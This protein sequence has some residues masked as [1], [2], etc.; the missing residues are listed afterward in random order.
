MRGLVGLFIV[1]FGCHAQPGQEAQ[2]VCTVVCRCESPLSGVQATCVDDCTRNAP[3]DIP[4]DCVTCVFE[5]ETSCGDLVSECLPLC[6]Q[7]EPPTEGRPTW[8]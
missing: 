8:P 2:D 5:H 6:S 3:S 4:D 1:A 7:Q